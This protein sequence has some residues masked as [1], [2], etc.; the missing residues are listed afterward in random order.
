MKERKDSRRDNI[1]E[2]TE[3]EM[4]M[5]KHIRMQIDKRGNLEKRLKDKKIV[6]TEGLKDNL[7]KILEERKTENLKKR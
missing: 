1:A 5:I 2:I 3:K 7:V 6:T 4:K